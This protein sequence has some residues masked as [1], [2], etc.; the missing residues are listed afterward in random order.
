MK[1]DLSSCESKRKRV[2][3]GQRFIYGFVLT[4]ISSD[5]FITIMERVEER[6]NAIRSLVDHAKIGFVE[7]E[8]TPLVFELIEDLSLIAPEKHEQTQR[9]LDDLCTME[10]STGLGNGMYS[11]LSNSRSPLTEGVLCRAIDSEP[12]YNCNDAAFK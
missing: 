11:R 1:T 6:L 4:F 7:G 2:S 10:K 12:Y 9:L 8:L 3:R 5:N